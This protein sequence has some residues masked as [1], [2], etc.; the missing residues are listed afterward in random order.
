MS[1][2]GYNCRE[3]RKRAALAPGDISGY[4][5]CCNLA[6]SGAGGSGRFDCVA[7]RFKRRTRGP[8]PPGNGLRDC[9]YVGIEGCVVAKVMSGM[10]SDDVDDRYLSSAGIVEI[11]EAITKARAEME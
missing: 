5:Q 6:W 2:L 8:Q 1:G 3:G 9:L 4:D 11:C 10:L 7:A